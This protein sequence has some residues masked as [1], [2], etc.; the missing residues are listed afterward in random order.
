MS[1]LFKTYVLFVLMFF[2]AIMPGSSMIPVT[3]RFSARSRLAPWQEAETGVM[4]VWNRITIDSVNVHSRISSSVNPNCTGLG[5]KEVEAECFSIQQNFWLSD[6]NGKV[7]LW[8]QNV[9][10]LAGLEGGPFFAKYAFLVWTPT[11]ALQG[12]QE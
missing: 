11:E 7:A 6:S 12:Y 2:P 8:V 10:E 5:G 4:G 1:T 9:V 3:Q